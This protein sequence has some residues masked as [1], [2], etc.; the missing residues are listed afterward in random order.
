MSDFAD[1]VRYIAPSE[2]TSETIGLRSIQTE[3]VIVIGAGPVAIRFAMEVL[4]RHAHAAIQIFG[5]EPYHPYNRVQLSSLL[6]GDIGYEDVITQL[7][8]CDQFPNFSFIISAIRKIDINNQTVEDIQGVEYAFDKLIIATGS[9]PHQP[10]I[11]GINQTGVYTF[12]TLKDTE[13]LYA[14]RSRSRHVVVVGGGL[15]GIESAKALLR[16]NTQVTLVQQGNRLMNRQLD[17]KA[18]QKL[19]EKLQT[20]GIRIITNSGVRQ[21]L[22]TG[23]V[24]GVITRD[25]EE[26]TCDTVLLCAGVRAN[27]ELAR[28]AGLKVGR[29]I[30]VDDQ[31]QTSA[32]NVYAIGECCE[33]RGSLYGLVNPGYEQAAVLADHLD[34]GSARYIGSLSVSRLKVLGEPVCSMGMVAD[35]E[36]DTLVR[37]FVFHSK[38]KGIYRKIILSRHKLIGAVGYGDWP[39][40]RQIQDAYQREKKIYPWHIFRFLLTGNI[41]GSGENQNVAA[42]PRSTIVCQCNNI[43]Q[44]VLADA[45][46]NGA[47]T[48]DA[49]Q[50]KT[51]AGSVCGSCKPL[52][53]NLIGAS[54]PPQKEKYYFLLFI[55]CVMAFIAALLV[56]Y[57]PP[58]TVADSVQQSSL[59]QAI[60]NNKFW[61][62]VTGFSLLGLSVMGLLMSVKKRWLKKRF[63]EFAFWRMIHMALGA[64]CAGILILHTGL[65]LG[66]NLNRWLMMNFLGV[67]FVGAAAGGIISLSHK[68]ATGGVPLRKLW[69]WC[70]IFLTWPLPVLLSF[71]I[72]SV[73]YF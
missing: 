44:G 14:R 10:D 47:V 23:R 38:N 56:A 37:A 55:S 46:S 57:L 17:D 16:D 48:F 52:L 22:G 58:L 41:F 62:Q 28:H 60:W 31:L 26:I 13:F 19:E 59:F 51:Q 32:E 73:Y 42:W 66:E 12:R 70:H 63:G 36:S 7:P 9:R 33:H 21:I 50:Q 6:A 61:N 40:S 69:T 1:A 45:I 5:N 34:G 11:P 68:M 71:H 64:V 20:L 4:Q 53:A 49:L 30:L 27:L 8:S 25:K 35:Y 29:A 72:L 65:N 43:N 67:L 24:E 2:C 3:R 15:L 18:S 54:E 39:E